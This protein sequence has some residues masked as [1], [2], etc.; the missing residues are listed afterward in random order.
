MNG[1]KFVEL[2]DLLQE[3]KSISVEVLMD[4]YFEAY[5]QGFDDA[6]HCVAAA[7]GQVNATTLKHQ[8]VEILNKN[9]G[10]RK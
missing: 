7:R 1:K 9:G 6:V 8:M 5:E 2:Y 4:F 10:I 3:E